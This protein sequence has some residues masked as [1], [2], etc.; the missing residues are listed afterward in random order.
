MEEEQL[1]TVLFCFYRGC[2]RNVEN[3]L[4]VK[5][6]RVNAAYHVGSL[7]A[8]Y[9]SARQYTPWPIAHGVSGLDI[10]SELESTAFVK[11]ARARGS[12][13]WGFIYKLKLILSI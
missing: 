5:K 13:F 1:L 4:H 2:E 11:V 3:E 6:E 9:L 8:V 12:F 7:T 10:E